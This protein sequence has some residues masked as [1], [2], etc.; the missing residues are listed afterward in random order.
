MMRLPSYDI[1]GEAHWVACCV[2]QACSSCWQWLA[3]SRRIR[4]SQ[5]QR[6]VECTSHSVS[7]RSTKISSATRSATDSPRLWRHTSSK[8]GSMGKEGK[9][10]MCSN[11]AV[12][13]SLSSFYVSCPCSHMSDAFP[14]TWAFHLSLSFAKPLPKPLFSDYP[15]QPHSSSFSVYVFQHFLQYPYFCM[16]IRF[17]LAN[18]FSYL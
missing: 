1:C 5:W 10:A 8:W 17:A 2:L 7:Q 15:S 13:P 16:L 6:T 9:V 18:L 11:L 12:S 14:M 4:Q 3:Q